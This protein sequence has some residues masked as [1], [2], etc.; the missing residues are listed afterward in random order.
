VGARLAAFSR[1]MSSAHEEVLAFWFG[2][3]DAKGRADQ[4]HAIRW[5][6]KDEA[7]DRE[8]RERFGALHEAILRG[9]HE[10]WLASPRGRL[11][12]V[13]VLD[14][15]SRNMFRGTPRMFAADARALEV[16]EEGIARGDDR[17]L[18][19][20]ER[21]FLYMPLEHAEDLAA[22]ERCVELFRAWREEL[23]TELRDGLTE[24]LDYAIAHRDIIARFGR[25]PHRNAILGRESTAEEL[26]F[27]EQPGSSF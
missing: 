15:F 7:F 4:A 12:Y 26:E 3:L 27:L 17:A 5:W 14:Q 22:Q 23:P 13:I 20:A 25:F 6:K 19:F 24:A 11:A 21:Q 1:T 9:E 16:A 2:E 10:D 18:A 8:I